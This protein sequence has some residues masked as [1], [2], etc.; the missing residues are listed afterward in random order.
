MSLYEHTADVSLYDGCFCK[1]AYLFALSG[2]CVRTPPYFW[3]AQRAAVKNRRATIAYYFSTD[4]V[5]KFASGYAAPPVC[6][7][8]VTLTMYRE[9]RDS[10]GGGI[11]LQFFFFFDIVIEISDELFTQIHLRVLHATFAYQGTRKIKLVK[12]TTISGDVI[13][14]KKNLNVSV[15]VDE[16]ELIVINKRLKLTTPTD[17]P[18]KVP[19]N[20][21][22]RHASATNPTHFTP[23]ACIVTAPNY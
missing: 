20:R 13:D 10:P 21:D 11:A 12:Y 18:I 5:F 23:Y 19:K 17:Q 1:H 8:G 6:S 15:R 2:G 9:N 3:Y 14:K 7:V 4:F 22:Y 16:T